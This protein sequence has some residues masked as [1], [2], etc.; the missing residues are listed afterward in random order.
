MQERLKLVHGELTIDTNPGH[1]TRIRA[2]V[3]RLPPTAGH[4]LA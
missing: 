1:G 2:R 3:P 4:G